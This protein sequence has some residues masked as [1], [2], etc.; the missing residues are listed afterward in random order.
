MERLKLL[1][2]IALCATLAPGA[3]ASARGGGHGGGGHGG[4]GGH[5]GCGGG[6]HGGGHFGGG[7]GH[8]GGGG[9]GF[10][11]GSRSFGGGSQSFGG[12]RA[13][14]VYRGDLYIVRTDGAE[15]PLRLTRTKSLEKEPRLSPDGTKLAFVRDGQLYSQDL[16]T[17]QLWHASDVE[18][19]GGAN[20]PVQG[21]SLRGLAIPPAVQTGLR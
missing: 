1:G 10:G 17:G 11:G 6:F 20:L 3:A 9:G 14:F 8:Y 13:A 18:G 16:R 7:G 2:V 4:G 12:S 5:F 15:P 21:L 19:E